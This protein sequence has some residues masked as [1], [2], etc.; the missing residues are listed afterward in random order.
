MWLA[1]SMFS[2][3][4]LCNLC[5]HLWRF[6]IMC[7]LDLIYGMWDNHWYMHD[8]KSMCD[9][10]QTKVVKLFEIYCVSVSRTV[11]QF[12]KIKTDDNKQQILSEVYL[13]SVT[14][15]LEDLWCSSPIYTWQSFFHAPTIVKNISPL[16]SLAFIAP[17]LLFMSP[18][19]RANISQE[20]LYGS[21]SPVVLL[22][23]LLPS[24]TIFIQ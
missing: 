19:T 7:A 11:Q 3:C 23:S 15:L 4:L 5:C 13:T 16:K 22:T 2:L 6:M 9:T 8:W 12:K 20:L 10:R 17:S 21:F 1:G 24:L 14:M 18:A